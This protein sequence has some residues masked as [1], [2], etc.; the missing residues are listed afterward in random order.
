MSLSQPAGLRKIS[1]GPRTDVADTTAWVYYPLDTAVPAQWRGRLAAIRN[2]AGNVTRFENYDVFGNAGRL[3]DANGVAAEATFDAMGRVLTSTLKGVAGCDTTADPL[4]ATDIVSSRTYQPALGPLASTTMPGGGTTT[5]EYDSRGRTS[6]T[7]RQVTAAAYERIEYDYDPATGRKSAERYLA[8][9]PGAWT[10]VR[11]EAFQYDTFARLREIDHPDGSKVVYRYDGANN[12]TSVQDERHTA[13]NTTYAYDSTNRLSLVTQTL[14]SAPSSQVATAYAYDIHG[15]LTSVTD[16]NG[17]VTSYVYDDFG[18]MIQQTSPVTGATTYTYDP[19]GNLLSTIDANSVTTTRVYDALNR[20]TS[21]ASSGESTETTSWTYDGTA[22]FAL[23]RLETM[24]DPT[25]ST[26]YGYERR[27]SL[28]HEQKIVGSATYST[29]YQYDSDGNRSLMTYPSGRIVTYAF[30]FVGRPLTAVSGGTTLVSSASYLPFGPATQLVFG[31]GTTKT[32]IYDSRYRVLENKLTSSAGVIADYNYAEDPAGNITQIHDATDPTF[33]RDF[34]YDDLN[35]LVT[36]NS[37]SSLWGNGTYQYDSMGNLLSSALGASKSLSLAYSGTTPKLSSVATNGSALSVEYDAGG[38]ELQ[39]DGHSYHYSPRNTLADADLVSYAYDGRGVRAITSY[40]ASYL[41]TLQVTPTVLYTNQNA[42]GTVTLAAAA[43]AGGVVVHLAS[44]SSALSVPA[45]VTVPAGGTSA[46]FGI[47]QMPGAQP[48][49]VTITAS[50]LYSATSTI[51]VVAG[52]PIASIA[53]NPSTIAGGGTATGTVA[54]SAAAPSGGAPV[55]LSSDSAAATVPGQATIAAGQTEASFNVATATVTSSTTAHITA[56]YSGTVSAVLN[57]VNGVS[58]VTISPTSVVGGA[59]ATGTVVLLGPAPAGGATV[60]L[61]S[62]APSIATVPSTV[63]VSA[64]ATA[65]SFAITSSSVTPSIVVTITASLAGSSTGAALTVNPCTLTTAA[66]PTIPSGDTVWFDDTLP[67]GMSFVDIRFDTSQKASGTQSLH[68]GYGTGSFGQG[69]SNAAQPLFQVLPGD[70]LV[71]YMLMNPCAKPREVEVT[72]YASGYG[73]RG[74]Y[75]G[76]ALTGDESGKV[77]MGALPTADGWVRMEV[78]ANLLNGVEGNTLYGLAL[79]RFDGEVWFDRFARVGT[80]SV[81]TEAA[82]PTIPSGD[83]V[84]FDDMLPSGMSFVDIR[85]DTSQKASGTQSLHIGYGTG[86]FGQ[87]TSNAAQ[88][89]FQ[90]LPGD[91]LVF[92]MLMNPCA[93]PREVEVTWYASGYG[94]RGAYWGTALTGDESGKVSM[95]ALPTADGWVRMEVPASLLN[96]V[97]G[98]TLYGLALSRFD[99]EVWFDRFATAPG[100]NGS[101]ALPQR[102][103]QSAVAYSAGRN[104]AGFLLRV[105][106]VLTRAFVRARADH[107]PVTLSFRA[108]IRELSA[109]VSQRYSLYTP[110]LNL[111]AETEQTNAATP[112][113]AYEYVWFGGQPVAQFDVATNTPHWTFTDHLGTPIL[114]TNAAGAVDWRAEYE[115]FG[116]VNTLRAGATRHQPLR[117]PGQEYDEASADREYNIFRWY[118]GA[119]GRYTQSDPMGLHGGLN[120]YGYTK[121]NPIIDFDPLGLCCS[122]QDYGRQL[123]LAYSIAWSVQNT[124]FWSQLFSG[125]IFKRGASVP[126]GCGLNADNLVQALN[127]R[128]TCWRASRTDA[129][130]G[131]FGFTCRRIIPHS[132]A[133]LS[134]LDRC[135][136]AKDPGHIA[137]DNYFG[138]P[139]TTPFPDPTKAPL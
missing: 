94:P 110:E 13:A 120:V 55:L 52:P 129:G 126:N 71:F 132:F 86:S 81:M 95:G 30:D 93:K 113:I 28:Q 69:T 25:G 73:P 98:N 79:S 53:I 74:A 36:A 118:R 77:S 115:P 43:P 117:F 131:I 88:P 64:G 75:W 65:A 82:Q 58:S 34:G 112:A 22:P 44:S 20:V 92:Y 111:M 108:P 51:S 26:S 72:W 41:S 66:Q 124:N 60:S 97:E 59:S 138:P 103:E 139:S 68:I 54:L 127:S 125:G 12:L 107:P 29:A 23:G 87:G 99:G 100:G 2:A 49:S 45:T 62:G 137:L 106:N 61:A 18:R 116:T 105:R 48:G 50:Y 15:N 31:N 6:A 5:Y 102:M 80:C 56:N 89:L 84:W 17:N 42:T 33:N 119:W 83:T 135:C 76:T 70:R 114:Q 4:C 136:D 39:A 96:G 130:P 37:G 21:A 38:N 16:P 35:R 40:P 109:D 9:H 85:F 67:S 57:V 91:R 122:N 101:L 27:G 121:G 133:T 3:V 134:P 10:V 19:A 63:V 7:T 8:G 14:S 90:V 78:P 11:S 24:T 123:L 46:V 128:L 1:D 104:R 47:S 32:M